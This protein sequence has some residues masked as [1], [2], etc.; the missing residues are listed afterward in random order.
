ML[1]IYF[2]LIKAD[3]LASDFFWFRYALDSVV[4]NTCRIKETVKLSYT[5]TIFSGTVSTITGRKKDDEFS[6]YPLA[7]VSLVTYPCG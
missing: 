4:S 2:L 5:T 7:T 6:Q 3:K 1:Y